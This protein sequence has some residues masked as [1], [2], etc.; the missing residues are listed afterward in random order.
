METISPDNCRTDWCPLDLWLL[1]PS[2]SHKA[3]NAGIV[4]YREDRF[5]AGGLAGCAIFLLL[6]FLKA[7]GNFLG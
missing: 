6:L 3:K 2:A 7:F 1:L 5:W 4:I